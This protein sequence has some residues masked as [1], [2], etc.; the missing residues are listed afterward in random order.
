VAGALEEV[1]PG[2][3]PLHVIE[4]PSQPNGMPFARIAPEAGQVAGFAPGE[5]VPI[6]LSISHAEGHTLC[7]AT[8]SEP[9]DDGAR[10]TLGID[11][12]L[13]E[14]RSREFVG[15]F[16]TEDEQRFV[17]EA[18]GSQRDLRA[19]LIWCAKEAVLKALG[20]GLTVDTLELSCL[21]EPG[22]AD[23]AEWPL[24]PA[25]GA[26]RPFV[27]RCGPGLV[28][29]GGTIRGIWRSFPGFVGALASQA[30]T[31][32]SPVSLPGVDTESSTG[33]LSHPRDDRIAEL[34][35]R[36]PRSRRIAEPGRVDRG[37]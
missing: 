27:A 18:P 26:W 34:L 3:W 20:V 29:G 9:M 12:G 6:A 31:L 2:H 1:F 5:R 17:R 22:L 33:E 19:N 25:D 8:F 13:I 35:H 21:P 16:F 32:L 15:T 23:P 11:L 30:A 28:S 14:P 7:A 24:A 37:R 10:R 4:I 36:D